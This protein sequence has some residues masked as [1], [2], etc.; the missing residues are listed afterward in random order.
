MIHF[1]Y[2][3]FTLLITL[4]QTFVTGQEDKHFVRVLYE[5]KDALQC[6]VDL[7]RQ[8]K[9]EILLSYFIIVDDLS[10]SILL[11]LLAEASK[12]RGV[13]V[14]ILMDKNG[15]KISA[16]MRA[17]L[18]KSGVELHRFDLK[19][20][21][22]ER[23]YHGLHEKML[24][25]DGEFLIVG[26]RNIQDPYYG[27][28][29]KFNLIDYDLLT[30]ADSVLLEARFHFYSLWAD[31]KLSSPFAAPTVKPQRQAR[32]LKKLVSYKTEI[33]EKFG[34]RLD[35]SRNWRKGYQM[36]ASDVGFIHDDFFIK[37]GK[38]YYKTDIKDEGSTSALIEMVKNA[39]HVIF[40]ENPYFIPTKRWTNALCDASNRGVRICLLTTSMMTNDLPIR[41]AGYRHRRNK[42]LS[43]GI[44]IWEFQGHLRFHGKTMLVDSQMLVVGSYNI[45]LPSVRYN[46]EVAVWT[47]DKK[48]VKRHIDV[49]ESRL[50][51]SLQIGSNN[52][53]ISHPNKK[54]PKPSLWLCAKT[55]F[56][57][58]TVAPAFWWL[59]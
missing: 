6:R 49:W 2:I 32:H 16:P 35:S 52:K 15:S 17:L 36:N 53:P 21:G 13:L 1:R 5:P 27:M 48:A 23:L 40:I 14:R 51:N 22:I 39:K 38:K 43:D 37:R 30:N 7:I 31:E 28:S 3:F 54:F 24:I 34:I 55:N 19:N 50:E 11:N 12:E 57:R 10:G 46:T 9:K 29:K 56:L 26:G 42:I 47:K 8:A 4:F 58:Y 41:Y 44:E 18:E 25:T 33:R 20:K 59:L 45:H